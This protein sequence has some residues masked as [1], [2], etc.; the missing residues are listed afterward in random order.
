ML[1]STFNLRHRLCFDPSHFISYSS[2]SRKE[3][4]LCLIHLELCGSPDSW[5]AMGNIYLHK[6]EANIL[7]LSIANGHLLMICV[8]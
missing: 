4:V 6:E 8:S 7:K 1:N 5:G 2:A 3:P